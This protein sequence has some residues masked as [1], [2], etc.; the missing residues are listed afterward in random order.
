MKRETGQNGTTICLKSRSNCQITNV[1]LKYR[2]VGGVIGDEAN[3]FMQIE[4]FNE[5]RY[6]VNVG[7]LQAL[8]NNWRSSAVVRAVVECE[9]GGELELS[10]NEV[11]SEGK[12]KSRAQIIL[13]FGN[14]VEEEEEKKQ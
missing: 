11:Y 1:H 5:W 12:K 10:L 6:Q 14:E 3:C 9:D 2:A 7:E 13:V 4:K 8:L